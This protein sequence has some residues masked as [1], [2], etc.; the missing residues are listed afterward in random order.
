VTAL[1]RTAAAAAALVAAAP[2]QAGKGLAPGEI[3]D[4]NR[5]TVAELM[6]LPGVGESKARAVVA[7]R[8]RQPFRR[9]EDVLKVKGFGKA[10]FQKVKANLV[11]TLPAANGP[12]QAPAGAKATASGPAGAAAP[13]A[14]AR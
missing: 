13:A 9:P 7:Y 5:A 12:A 3:I 4:L 10:W 11:A 6:H 14:S 8:Q 1:V 2:A